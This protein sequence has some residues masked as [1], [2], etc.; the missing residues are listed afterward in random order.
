MKLRN[1]DGLRRDIR[2]QR[3][4]EIHEPA[5]TRFA[6]SHDIANRFLVNSLRLQVPTDPYLEKL[7]FRDLQVLAR[8][9]LFLDAFLLPPRGILKPDDTS[10]RARHMDLSYSRNRYVTR[11]RVH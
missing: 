10:S 2:G 8:L 7:P 6:Y 3:T 4:N 1:C 9:V 11:E 5:R